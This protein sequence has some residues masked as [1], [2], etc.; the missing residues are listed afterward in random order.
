MYM[1]YPV[2]LQPFKSENQIFPSFPIPNVL[3]VQ[4][5]KPHEQSVT[6]KDQQASAIFCDTALLFYFFISW[7]ETEETWLYSS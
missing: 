5:G 7:E 6:S 2:C 3:S 1:H 4:F